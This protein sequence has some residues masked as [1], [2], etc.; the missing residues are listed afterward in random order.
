MIK[1]QAIFAGRS[2]EPVTLLS[3]YDEEARVLA[4][5]KRNPYSEK[6][7]E[8]FEVV[9]NVIGVDRE[10]FFKDDNMEEAIRIFFEMSQSLSADGMSPQL[11]FDDLVVAA[12]PSSQ[13]EIDGMDEHGEKYR[14]KG[15][16]TN[17][18]AAVLATCLFVRRQ[19]AVQSTIDMTKEINKFNSLVD[20]FIVTI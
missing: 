13:I 10:S 9:T 1:I 12:D 19:L 17:V 4:F 3:V 16:L 15:D 2:G 14:F 7:L 18:E 5:V 8:G 20:G 6:R 11:V